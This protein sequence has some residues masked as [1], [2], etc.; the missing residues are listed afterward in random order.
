MSALTMTLLPEPVAPAI[1]R[2]GILPRSTAIGRSPTSRPSAKVRRVPDA[3]KSSSWRI[4]R[5]GTIMKSLFGI[6]M[7]TALLPGIGA[8]IRRLRAARAMARSSDSA[9]TRLTFTWGAGW[10]SYWVTTGPALR[11]TIVTSIPKLAS[12]LTMISSFRAWIA[13]RL[14]VARAVGASASSSSSCGGSR[15]STASRFVGES[16]TSITS[17]L[18]GS[19]G[20]ATAA[21]AAVP[22]APPPGP[23]EP[24]TRSGANVADTGD[25][26][27]TDVGMPGAGVEPGSVPQT[28]VWPGASTAAM[29]APRNL[30]AP[31]AA[32]APATPR[33][34][35]VGSSAVLGVRSWS[36][37]PAA[38]AA[39]VAGDRRARNGMSR[40]ISSP[41]MDS[42]MRM[43][44]APGVVSAGSRRPA[45]NRPM[46]P[47]P[48]PA[49]IWNAPSPPA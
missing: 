7:P 36:V 16:A 38:R 37:D 44:R 46:C 26:D 35:G 2:C 15:H 19:A 28:P 25:C 8:S 21:R 17:I 32:A 34:P 13:S 47:P 40:A 39:R 1:S 43:T 45:R 48:R 24:P 6:S 11:P 30:R 33:L 20:S 42:P 27:G 49:M 31:S 18:A 3:L 22:P 12:F 23:D 9:S 10:T 4:G 41:A 14:P 29:R 5:S